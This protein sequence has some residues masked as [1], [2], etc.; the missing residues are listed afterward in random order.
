[1]S[2]GPNNWALV[3]QYLLADLEARRR[4]SRWQL[5]R[6]VV[7]VVVFAL[8]AVRLMTLGSLTPTALAPHVAVVHVDGPIAQELPTNAQSLTDALRAAFETTEA[9]GVILRINSPGGSPVQ[10]DLVYR[11]IR[12]LRAQYPD[13]PVHAVIEDIGAS[14]A[15]YIAVAADKI[16]VNPASIVGS[17]GVIMPSFG[18]PDLLK[19]LGV[20]DRTLTAG[21]NKNILS[22]T[23]P[24]DPAQQ[25]HVQSLLDAVHG[26]F[27]AAVKAG[28]GDRLQE[29]P[30]IFS[31]LFWDGGRA[32]TLGL[33]DEVGSLDSVAREVF[34]LE[35]IID[36]TY[37]PDPFDTV[38]RG[39]GVQFGAGVAEALTGWESAAR[40]PRFTY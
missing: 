38:L 26:A 19:R 40:T 7:F 13:K 35:E 14:G 25:A 32:V 3:E 5:I 20:E 31:G 9:K 8:I 1:M 37:Y 24:I 36:Y 10:S 39:L 34:K 27:I 11:E 22:P 30:T 12:R 17:I 6:R 21:D 28:R 29:D 16:Y 15:Y 23:A 33:A 4:A 18:V 2:E